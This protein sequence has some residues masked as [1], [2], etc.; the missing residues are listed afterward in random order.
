MPRDYY[1]PAIIRRRRLPCVSC[2]SE[3]RFA[4]GFRLLPSEEVGRDASFTTIGRLQVGQRQSYAVSALID[5]GVVAR[6]RLRCAPAALRA[7]DYADAMPPSRCLRR[8]CEPGRRD[9]AAEAGFRAYAA[10]GHAA[11]IAATAGR[12]GPHDE[13]Q[14]RSTRCSRDG[15][16]PIKSSRRLSPYGSDSTGRRTAYIA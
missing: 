7:L 16:L 6:S 15:C 12:R 14:R 4:P 13:H 10:L 9:A 3:R 11:A 1:F 2:S 8:L 5:N